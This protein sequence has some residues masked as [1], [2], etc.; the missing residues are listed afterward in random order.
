MTRDSGPRSGNK[1]AI[2]TATEIPQPWPRWMS[3]T[4]A[5]AYMGGRSKD[6]VRMML[7]RGTLPFVQQGKRV[8]VDREDVDRL[9]EAGKTSAV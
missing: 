9:M 6:A 3:L 2:G 5:G 8:L 1:S 4:Q 7:R